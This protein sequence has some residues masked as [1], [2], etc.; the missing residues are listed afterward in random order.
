MRKWPNEDPE[1]AK[2]NGPHVAV[3]IALLTVFPNK[4]DQLTLGALIH[5]RQEGLAQGQWALVGRMVRERERLAEAP[6][7]PSNQGGDESPAKRIRKR[8]S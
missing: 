8:D 4:Q 6:R 2:F 5:R 7:T 3:D 1:L